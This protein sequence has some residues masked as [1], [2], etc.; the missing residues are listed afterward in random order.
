MEP[1]DESSQHFAKIQQ[2]CARK[3]V[4]KKCFGVLQSRFDVIQNPC[5]WCRQMD[6]ISNFMIVGC[7]FITRLLK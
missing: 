5:R 3:N 7:L 6:V 4:L 1:K 2:E